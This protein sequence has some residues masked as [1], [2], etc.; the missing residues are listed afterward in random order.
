MAWHGTMPQWD[1]ATT[2]TT[3]DFTFCLTICIFTDYLDSSTCTA[4]G[5]RNFA[6][7]ELLHALTSGKGGGGVHTTSSQLGGCPL[8]MTDDGRDIVTQLVPLHI[9]TG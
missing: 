7:E 4:L 2:S 8:Q 9:C 5:Y 6:F 3:L 1:T